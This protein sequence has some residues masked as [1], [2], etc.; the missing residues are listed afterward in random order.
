M[1][2]PPV[3]GDVHRIPRIPERGHPG[4]HCIYTMKTSSSDI[5][6]TR[7]SQDLENTNRFARLPFL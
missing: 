5:L 6:K 2:A 3:R 7:V 1:N 4:F